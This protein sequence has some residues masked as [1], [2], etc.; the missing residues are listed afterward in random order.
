[1]LNRRE[2]LKQAGLLLAGVGAAVGGVLALMPKMPWRHAAMQFDDAHRKMWLWIDGELQNPPPGYV[3]PS[4][5]VAHPNEFEI[6]G[7]VIAS[8]GGFDAE[9]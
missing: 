3:S 4:P 6:E 9:S 7:G 1:M 5:Q 2:F 8:W